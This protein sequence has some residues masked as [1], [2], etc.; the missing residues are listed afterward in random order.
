MNRLYWMIL[1]YLH[2]FLTWCRLPVCE[3]FQGPCF[4]LGERKRQNTQYHDSKL[5]WTTQCPVCF[6]AEWDA[7]Q[8]RWDEYYSSIL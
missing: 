8:E 5:N 4:K 2:R 6:K 1:V 3:G 7:W